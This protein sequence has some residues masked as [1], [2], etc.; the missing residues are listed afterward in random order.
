MFRSLCFVP[1]T[2]AVLLA[3]ASPTFAQDDPAEVIARRCVA[4]VDRAVDRNRNVAAEKTAACLETIRGLLAAGNERRAILEARRCIDAAEDRAEA[5]A[6]IV[7]RVCTECRQ[8]LR[9]LGAFELAAR[10]DNVCDD[11]IAELRTILQRQKNAL[12]NALP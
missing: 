6:I 12:T 5:S 2:V 11:A 7:N 10:V 3:T 4:R 1:A 9:E 8:T